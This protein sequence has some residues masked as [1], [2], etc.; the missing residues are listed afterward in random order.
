MEHRTATLRGINIALGIWLFISAFLW[1]HGRGE[2]TNTWVVGALCVLFALIALW[3]PRARYA[4]AILAVWLF[5]SA[6]T[7]PVLLMATVWNNA[8]VAVAILVVSLLAT[9]AVVGRTRAAPRA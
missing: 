9:E 5:V 4:T 2:F 3:A 8:L 1:R 6:W 7:I